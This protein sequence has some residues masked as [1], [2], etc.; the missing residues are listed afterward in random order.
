MRGL[1][2]TRRRP[3][4]RHLRPVRRPGSRGPTSSSW[5]TRGRTKAAKRDGPDL[6]GQHPSRHGHDRSAGAHRCCTARAQPDAVAHGLKRSGRRAAHPGIRHRPAT[7]GDRHQHRS[8]EQPAQARV[9]SPPHA[10][11]R[12]GR[13]Q[14]WVG[15]GVFCRLQ[16]P[17]HDANRTDQAGH[18]L[19]SDPWRV[20]HCGVQSH[21]HGAA[22]RRD[23]HPLSIGTPVRLPASRSPGLAGQHR[24]AIWTRHAHAFARPR[25]PG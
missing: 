24:E 11:A 6:P 1:T 7:R 16:P 25:R 10:H 8:S 23:V 13:S 18:P 20:R 4:L 21:Q 15:P 22:P 5:P 3:L 9:R 2:S 12:P 19:P 14:C 17:P